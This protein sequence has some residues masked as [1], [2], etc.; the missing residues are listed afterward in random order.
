VGSLKWEVGVLQGP[1][2]VAQVFQGVGEVEG[3]RKMHGA[4]GGRAESKKGALSNVVYQSPV[5]S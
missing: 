3:C 2:G 5:G 1:V 4:G